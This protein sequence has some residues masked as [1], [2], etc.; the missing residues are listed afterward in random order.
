MAERDVLG[1]Q[2]V[3]R[4]DE[5]ALLYA[6]LRLQASALQAGQLAYRDRLA[7]QRLLRTRIA[8]LQREITAARC[9]RVLDACAGAQALYSLN[10]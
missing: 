10:K 5:V 2:L 4:N 8:T 1:T 6:K 7:E 9:V 3:R